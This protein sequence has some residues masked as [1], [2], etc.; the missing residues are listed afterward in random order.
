[1][2]RTNMMTLHELGKS[3]AEAGN[4]PDDMAKLKRQARGNR[5]IL[6]GFSEDEIEE[7]MHSYWKFKPESAT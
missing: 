4:S 2:G 7:L 1:M 3:L 5:G 6:R